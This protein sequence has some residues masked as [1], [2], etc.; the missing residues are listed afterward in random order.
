[1]AQKWGIRKMPLKA[2]PT[3]ITKKGFESLQ[4]QPSKN[5]KKPNN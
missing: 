3:V 2:K 5:I 1:M 4:A